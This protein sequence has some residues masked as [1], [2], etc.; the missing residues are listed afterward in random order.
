[1]LSRL[2]VHNGFDERE[3]RELFGHA[4]LTSFRS[5]TRCDPDN[6][7]AIDL[8]NLAARTGW[9][10]SLL[11]ASFSAY[12]DWP[13]TLQL[14]TDSIRVQRESGRTDRLA[15][16]LR[17]C[18]QCA[19]FGEHLLFHQM[20]DWSHC[21][22]HLSP[23]TERCAACERKFERYAYPPDSTALV[24]C[25]GCGW[26]PTAAADAAAVEQGERRLWVMADYDDWLRRIHAAGIEG[27]WRQRLFVGPRPGRALAGVHH[28]IP[29]PPWVERCLDGVGRLSLVS[30]TKRGRLRRPAVLSQTRSM[31]ELIERSGAERYLPDGRSCGELVARMRFRTARQV[32]ALTEEFAREARRG[33]PSLALTV[34]RQ[35][36]REYAN[37]NTMASDALVAFGLWREHVHELRS[38]PARLEPPSSI[39]VPEVF[40]PLWL[41]GPGTLCRTV[42]THPD[43]WSN[44]EIG[45]WVSGLWW[46]QVLRDLR[47]MF[48]SLVEVARA[49]PDVMGAPSAAP[50]EVQRYRRAID[51][52]RPTFASD[53][54]GL[55][56]IA[57]APSLVFDTGDFPIFLLEGDGV[58]VTF[59]AATVSCAAGDETIRATPGAL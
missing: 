8:T 51:G 17:V 43:R 34:M 37:V 45:L 53:G 36:G 24:R 23:L 22:L 14:R 29:G 13:L 31:V 44:R 7:E 57:T 28:L 2:A 19:R 56:D 52:Q 12:Y 32:K 3:C 54:S 4:G 27:D 26:Q 40:L 15:R 5:P 42:R 10:V 41:R 50:A 55:I 46:E 18:L 49:E 21:P 47:R 38:D 11:E 30:H 39:V 16:T 6:P 1:M 9:S 35:G 33:D 25:D 59:T 48:L 20:T 58:R